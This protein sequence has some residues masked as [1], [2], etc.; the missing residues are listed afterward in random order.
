LRGSEYADWLAATPADALERI[1][2]VFARLGELHA[3]DLEEVSE[4]IRCLGTRA[5]FEHWLEW[6]NR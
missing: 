2:N 6:I 4:V 1:E 3:G 5:V